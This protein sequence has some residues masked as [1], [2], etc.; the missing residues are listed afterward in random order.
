MSTEVKTLVESLNRD[1]EEFK[2]ANDKGRE[3]LADRINKGIADTQ[4][5]IA[6]IETAMNRSAAVDAVAE[7]AEREALAR[8]SLKSFISN[9]G[10]SYYADV[11]DTKAGYDITTDANGK[12]GVPTVIEADLEKI[13]KEFS[14]VRSLANVVSIGTTAY[15]KLVNLNNTTVGNVSELGTRTGTDAGTFAKV[16]INTH[17]QYANPEVSL[18]MLEDVQFNAEAE[19]LAGMAEAFARKEGTDFVSG[20]GDASYQAKGFLTYTRND[21][22]DGSLGAYDKLNTVTSTGALAISADDIIN[23]I[24]A[25]PNEHAANAVFAMSR[26]IELAVRKLKD[27]NGH[28]LWQPSYQAGKPATLAGIAV[29]QMSDLPSSLTGTGSPVVPPCPIVLADWKRFYTVVDRVGVSILRDPYKVEGSVVF[30]ARKRQGG[31]IVNGAAGV[32]LSVKQS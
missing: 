21:I 12:Y 26:K 20:A 7:K 2:K 28:Y 9:G 23:L 11:L 18:Q 31:G 1:F 8:K 5:K 16:T 15:H 22:S 10:T 17:E 3:D 29:V 30:K 6:A 13:V 4:E 25:L 27:E 24:Y 19:L 32:A 14:P